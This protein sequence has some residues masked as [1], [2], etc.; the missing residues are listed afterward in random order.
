MKTT[1]LLGFFNLSIPGVWFIRISNEFEQVCEILHCKKYLL[2]ESKPSDTVT[3][4]SSNSSPTT[5]KF[6]IRESPLKKL[7]IIT[8]GTD[9][10]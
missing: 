6:P 4:P 10:C 8:R 5:L 9:K 2:R 1:L 3:Q 7:P